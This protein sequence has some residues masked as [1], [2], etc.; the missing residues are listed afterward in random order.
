ME[1]IVV[2]I[3]NK[4]HCLNITFDVTDELK[5]FVNIYIIEGKYLY[6][7]DCGVK[8]CLNTVNSYLESIGRDSSEIK[9]VFLTHTHPDHIG[10]LTE[11]KKYSEFELY[12]PKEEIEWIENIDKQFAERPIPNFYNLVGGSVKVNKE[13]SDGNII[14]PEEGITLKVIST[15]GHSTDSVSFYFEEE[16]AIFT[17]DALPVEE[18]I[19]MPIYISAKKSIEAVNRVKQ[20]KGLNYLL[21]AWDTPKKGKEIYNALKTGEEIL[22][23]IDESVKKL[24]SD[25]KKEKIEIFVKKVLEESGAENLIPMPLVIK[26]IESNIKETNHK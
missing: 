14:K 1:M 15:P 11:L 23:K 19:N 24:Y 6:L 12:C 21:S 3:T 22:T 4:I 18:S 10:G 20:I 5:R 8:G 25:Y 2:R 26:S 13:L 16:K 7:I 9:K 17:G